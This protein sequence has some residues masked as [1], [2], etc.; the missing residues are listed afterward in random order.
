MKRETNKLSETMA[1]NE[2]LKRSKHWS[3]MNLKNLEN[4]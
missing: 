3:K 2:T 1:H 4:Q